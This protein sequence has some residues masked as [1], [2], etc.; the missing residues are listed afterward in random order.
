MRQLT[1]SGFLK[2]YVQELSA[3]HTLDIK[4]LAHEAASTNARLQA[5]LVLYAVDAD[6]SALLARYL[7]ALDNSGD[8]L[9]ALSKYNKTTL[10]KQLQGNRETLDAYAKVWNSYCV[11]RD[12]PQREAAVKTAMRRKIQ[13]I[14]REK[15]CSNYRIYAALGLNPGNINSWLKN[16]DS[17]KVSYE[18]AVR[19]MDF[20]TSY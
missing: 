5:P 17:S 13:N 6:K 4:K 2:Q 15:S 20:V 10:A 19:I 8:M 11:L 9:Q 7:R 3:E 1:F 12:A 14:Q 16:G 18:T